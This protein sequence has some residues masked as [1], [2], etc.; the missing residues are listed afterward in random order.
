MYIYV[1]SMC[2]VCHLHARSTIHEH[3]GTNDKSDINIKLRK[4]SIASSPVHTFKPAQFMIAM[5]LA[6]I[7][8][9][10]Y[11]RNRENWM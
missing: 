10:S 3:S 7:D 6:I 9:L 2:T 11:L 5:F 8:R 4:G 1:H